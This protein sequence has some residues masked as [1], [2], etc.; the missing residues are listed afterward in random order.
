[1][2]N[3]SFDDLIQEFTY[4]DIPQE[5]DTED[6]D[7]LVLAAL[8]SND[9]EVVDCLHESLISNWGIKDVLEVAMTKGPE[10][11]IETLKNDLYACLEQYLYEKMAERGE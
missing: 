8:Y 5:L 3:F 6:K 9:Q 11:A 1:M 4:A 10:I 2:N 7:R